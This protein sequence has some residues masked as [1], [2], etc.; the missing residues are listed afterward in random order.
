MEHHWKIT[1][2]PCGESILRRRSKSADIL[3]ALDHH[4]SP[5]KDA[6]SP[7]LSNTVFSHSSNVH[8][9]IMT[10]AIFVM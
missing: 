8:F 6:S 4:A 5:I 10:D 2:W 9:Y 7:E 3:Y 1:I